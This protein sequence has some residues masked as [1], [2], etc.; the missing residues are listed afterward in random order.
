MTIT[1]A[2]RSASSPSIE[3]AF[4]ST[5][6]VV[7]GEVRPA[8][9]LVDDKGVIVDVV[10][11]SETPAGVDV[12][13]VVDAFLLPG[14]VDSHVHVNEPG[15][16]AWE[17]FATATQAAAKGGITSIVDMPLNSLPP[18]TNV[19]AFEEKL[20]AASG[21][22]A[23]DVGFW[24]GVIPKN[25]RQLLGLVD[26]GVL[27]FKCFLIDSGV[28]EFPNVDELHVDRALSILREAG[29]PLLTHAELQKPIDDVAARVAALD[30]R[31]YRYHLESRPKAAED[32]AVALMIAMCRKHKA[33]VHIVHHSSSTA[34]SMIEAA[35]HEGLPFTLETCPHYLSFAAEEID[36]GATH[37]KCT[38]PIRE[39]A[40]RDALWSAL[41]RGVLDAV[42]SDHS[43][44]TAALKRMDIGDFDRAWGGISSLQVTLPAT[45]TGAK[46]RGNSVVDVVRWMSEQP[47]KLAGLSRKGSIARG[48]D[49]DLV[50]FDPEARFVVDQETLAH[51]NKISPYHGRE[52]F[53]VVR[54]TWLRGQL[55]YRRGDDV[56]LRNGRVLLRGAA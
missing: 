4:V 14:L 26:A 24:G 16:T 35:R 50:A 6:V 9:V 55:V 18:T 11:R 29:V 28:P 22:L 41:K 39:R 12:V 48:K 30:H 8:A 51:R 21:Q 37:F 46:E 31:T 49:A 36:D 42:V 19:P 20:A 15:R 52:L 25:A 2:P 23:V 7:D 5:R 17:G 44:C 33:R 43:P 53:G 56:T 40:N 27:G 10:E 3:R 54:A 32:A 45:W 34:L 38:P 13:D 1:R 47:A